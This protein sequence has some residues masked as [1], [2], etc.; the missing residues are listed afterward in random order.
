MQLSKLPVGRFLHSVLAAALLQVAGS[1]FAAIGGGLWS[2]TALWHV[3]L[4]AVLVSLSGF[5]VKNAPSWLATIA[6]WLGAPPPAAGAALVILAL[7][8]LATTSCSPPQAS[9]APVLSAG[10]VGLFGALAPGD[11]LGPYVFTVGAV[12]GATGYSWTLTTSATNGTWS[13]VP[14]NAATTTPSFTFSIA[15]TGG[16]WDSVS[17]QLCVKGTSGVRSTKGPACTTWKVLRYLPTPTSMSG[18]SSRLGPISM[19]VR[20]P[21]GSLPIWGTGGQTAS[22]PAGTVFKACV[23]WRFGSGKVAAVGAD[24]T[25][26]GVIAAAQ[27][28]ADRRSGFTAAESSWLSGACDPWS[29]CLLGLGA[30]RS[31][32]DV[33]LVHRA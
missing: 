4:G 24:T 21:G 27:F 33:L 7:A 13:N 23:F 11:S 12:P 26:C 18:D 28:R 5:V 9:A 1:V 25:G 10:P 19:M 14:T 8:G 17:L 29:A 30:I 32:L 31:R 15:A 20:V 6:Q 22:Y 2:L 16:V 3:A